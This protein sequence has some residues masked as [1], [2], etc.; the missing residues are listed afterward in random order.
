MNEGDS[1]YDYKW[2]FRTVA[3]IIIVNSRQTLL[4]MTLSIIV[5]IVSRLIFCA[6]TFNNESPQDV[7][8]SIL[9]WIKLNNHLWV[10]QYLHA[11]LTKMHEGSNT[12]AL[13]RND[14]WLYFLLWLVVVSHWRASFLTCPRLT[15]TLLSKSFKDD[16]W[17]WPSC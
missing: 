5:V 11:S 2:L 4:S 15:S 1:K 7:L 3:L 10:P 14:V 16:G 9:C 13:W 17:R 8:S 12:H 6:I